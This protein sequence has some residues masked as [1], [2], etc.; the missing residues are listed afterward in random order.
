MCNFTLIMSIYKIIGIDIAIEISERDLDASWRLFRIITGSQ[1]QKPAKHSFCFELLKLKEINRDLSLAA[2]DNMNHILMANNQLMIANK[3]YSIAYAQ[4]AKKET[5]NAFLN[6]LFYS[7]AIKEGIIQLHCSVIDYNGQGIMF[8][9]PSGIGKTTQAECWEKYRGSTIINGDIGFVEKME[10]GF[11]AWGTPWHGSSQYCVNASVPLKALVVLKQADE[12]ELR[13]LEGF[14][15]LA[16]IS[17]NVFYPT[18]LKDG[19]DLCTKILGELLNSIAVYRLD[20]RADEA[21]VELLE[22]ELEGL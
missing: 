17:E 8:L 18:W 1:C 3:D 7:H 4:K 14:E 11:L 2:I 19:V 16:E 22:K 5:Y 13:R 12:N 10:N 15:K 20:N 9:G 21:A 6:Y